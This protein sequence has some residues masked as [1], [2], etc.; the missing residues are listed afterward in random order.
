MW[1]YYTFQAVVQVVV[2]LKAAGLPGSTLA[3][4]TRRPGK[5]TMLSIGWS[6]NI[7]ETIGNPARL[8]ALDAAIQ[9]RVSGPS[10]RYNATS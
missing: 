6:A 3:C 7:V 10:G 9:V 8:S 1:R 4:L 5:E 2:T